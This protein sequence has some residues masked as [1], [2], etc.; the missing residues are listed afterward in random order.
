MQTE[1][2]LANPPM[3]PESILLERDTAWLENRL[4]LIWQRYFAN[5][6]RANMV[7]IVFGQKSRTRLGSIGMEGWQGVKKGIAYKSRRNAA[8]GTSIITIT[9]YF[10]DLQIPDYVID[11]TIGHELVHYAHGFH[12]PHPQL[13][14]HPHQGGIVD[15][16]LMR[17]GMGETLYLQRKWLKKEWTAY[18]RSNGPKP[19]VRRRVIRKKRS[20]YGFL[21][22]LQPH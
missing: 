3:Q 13:Y 4:D 17:R 1:Q 22:F 19:V 5:V 15:S 14:R 7:L 16:E 18:L 10:K 11:A 21:S 12:S 2:P 6:E 20:N 9:G 8:Q